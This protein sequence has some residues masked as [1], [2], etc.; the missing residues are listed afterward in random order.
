MLKTDLEEYLIKLSDNVNRNVPLECV[1]LFGSRARTDY[2][3]HSDLDMIFVGQFEEPY[4]ERSTIIYD[5]YEL[6]L[7]L[8]PF[9]HRLYGEQY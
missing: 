3:E 8:H 7:V 2:R 1:I 5:C 6:S 4:I 9:Y